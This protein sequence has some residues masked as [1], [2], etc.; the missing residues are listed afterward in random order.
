MAYTL[1]QLKQGIIA[2]D[3]AGDTAAVQALGVEYRKM[4]SA[5]SSPPP[6][7]ALADQIP[8]S[9]PAQPPAPEPSWSE[10]LNAGVQAVGGTLAGLA[11]GLVAAPYGVAKD[12]YQRTV[13][14][15]PAGVSHAEDYAGEV[16]NNPITNSL[17]PST[18]LGKD[19][20]ETINKTLADIPAII[21]GESEIA[22]AAQMVKPA[23]TVAKQGV[24]R[25]SEAVN[26]LAENDYADVATEVAQ[27]AAKKVNQ[28]EVDAYGTK[29][30]PLTPTE[31]VHAEGLTDLNLFATPS[32]VNDSH[33]GT[34]ETIGGNRLQKTN[35]VHNENARTVGGRED[36]GLESGENIT[37]SDITHVIEKES[38]RA[39]EAAAELPPIKIS[40]DFDR[41]VDRIAANIS[42]I[43]T[44]FAGLVKG[45][46]YEDLSSRLSTL[47][48]TPEISASDLLSVV[49]R[50]RA[51]TETTLSTPLGTVLSPARKDLGAFTHALASE[52]ENLVIDSSPEGAAAT[53]VIRDARA[54]TAKAHDYLALLN[55]TSGK[56]DGPKL[57][58]L[59]KNSLKKDGTSLLSG[60]LKTMAEHAVTFPKDNASVLRLATES[61]VTP[62]DFL[63]G[64]ESVHD[65]LLGAA[66]VGRITIP[67]MISSRTIQN[68]L[69]S[70]RRVAAQ[71]VRTAR[72]EEHLAAMQKAEKS[73]EAA[74]VAAEQAAAKAA[75]EALK[76]RVLAEGEAGSFPA[77]TPKPE[78]APL[79]TRNLLTLDDENKTPLSGKSKHPTSAEEHL[80]FDLRQD[81]LDFPEQR[82]EIVKYINRAEKLKAK[83]SKAIDPDV[84]AKYKKHLDKVSN[85]FGAYMKSFGIDTAE[86][87][88]GLRRP[89]YEGGKRPTQ[90]PVVKGYTPP[91][92]IETVQ[93]DIRADRKRKIKEAQDKYTYRDRGAEQ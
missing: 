33:L 5:V 56:L 37:P 85:E 1:D 16:M 62:W 26:A 88:T 36:M 19:Y 11:T 77:A 23:M 7:G 3:A 72:S 68:K 50:L 76:P 53:A 22:A 14:N 6:S 60:K 57:A 87:A 66:V 92:S 84:I 67:H 63:L 17:Q 46:D 52:L 78:V 28:A 47:R 12:I 74:E 44:R 80:E 13:G 2:A 59:Y 21:P 89:L 93:R 90:L 9:K 15:A 4:Q 38:K 82:T 20:Q 81:V 25:V 8:G 54:K 30:T 91:K 73:A 49:R 86:D 45:A 31:K 64:M 18:S 42:D 69:V 71:T 41:K 24:R 83:I 61:T 79:A 29:V 27:E 35:T 40:S 75:E 58:T 70:E 10:K 39:D 32:R 55:P 34:L 43:P 51:E 48:K 65:P